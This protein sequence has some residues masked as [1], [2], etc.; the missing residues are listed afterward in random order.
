MTP[1][2]NKSGG[3]HG[4]EPVR[5][6]LGGGAVGF[7]ES[8]T[9]VPLV[10]IV[11]TFR[12]G[13]IADPE[14]KDGVGRFMSRMLR[15]GTE[16]MTSPE[17][18]SAIDRLGAELGVDVGPTTTSF[19]AQVIRRNLDPFVELFAKILGKPTFPDD[20]LARLRRESV[21]ELLDAR[22]ND[23]ALASLAFRR[24][25]FAGHPYARAAAGRPSTLERITKDDV[26]DA[27]AK[28]F[29]RADMVIGFAGAITADEA[30]DRGTRLASAVAERPRADL[31]VPETVM[32]S[33]RRLVFVDKPERTQT[34]ILI[35]TLG[36]HP[37]DPDHVPLVVANAVLGGSFTARMMREIRSKRGWSYG[38]S[39]RLQ[40]DRARRG[41]SMS[42]FPAATDC[43]K[44]VALELELLRAWVEGGITPRELAFV[45][46]F[47]TRSWAFEIDTAQKRV[48]HALD[49]ETLALPADYYTAYREHVR[50]VT[51]A[52]ANAA[53]KRRID[54]SRLVVTVLGTA[55]DLVDDVAKAIPDLGATTVIP[56]DREI[57]D[58]E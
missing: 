50:A 3:H 24:G 47:L 31:Q 57:D 16:G 51:R 39:S 10:S 34:Q 12:T 38:A 11:V 54:P 20:E 9:T 35:G 17:I 18:E 46:K 25:L 58:E 43:A 14:G 44:C 5:L 52:E 23:R 6:D 26:L 37:S 49:V 53:V 8:S 27:Y 1:K 48:D 33:G 45:Q 55:K 21:A 40:I 28:R 7:V 41:F 15:R 42:A 19:H 13:A 30:K 2:V 29:V 56:Y 4:K 32:P 36:T 22:D